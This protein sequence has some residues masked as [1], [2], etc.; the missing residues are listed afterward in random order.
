MTAKYDF[1]ISYNKADSDWAQWI[2]WQLDEAGYTTRFQEWDFGAGSNFALEM[3]RALMETE[4]TVAVLSPSSLKSEFCAQEWAATLAKD[5]ASKKRKLI[6][7]RVQECDPPGLLASIAYIDLFGKEEE[8]AKDEF[9][10]MVNSAL[11][12]AKGERAKPSESPFFPTREITAQLSK[13]QFPG[14]LPAIWRVPYN[15]NPNFTGRGR[16]LESL[17][18]QLTLGVP[19]ALTQAVSGL[20]GVGKTQ[21]ALEYTF[22]YMSD[23]GL[24][25]WV[26]SE[27]PTTM[28]ADIADLATPLGL[29]QA[30]MVEQDAKVAAVLKKLGQTPDW[31]LVFDNAAGPEEIRT[32]LPQ[33]STG[34][35]IITSRNDV[36][37]RLAQKVYVETF[38]RKESIEFLVKRTGKDDEAGAN[39]LAD[40]L[41]DLP[42]AL[43]QAGAYIEETGREFSDY[44]ELLQTRRNELLKLQPSPI[45]YPSTVLTTWDI[46]MKQVK[47]ESSEAVCLLNLFSFLAPD[48]IPRTLLSEIKDCP[49]KIISRAISDPLLMDKAIASLKRYSLVEMKGDGFFVHRL[50]QAVVRDSLPPADARNLLQSGFRIGYCRNAI[51]QRRSTNLATFLIA[52]PRMLCAVWRHEEDFNITDEN[53][54][55]LLNTLGEYFLNTAKLQGAK[56]VLER[57]VELRCKL[58]GNEHPDTAASLNSLGFLLQTIGKLSAA[59][60]YFEKALE[61]R[62]KV[63]GEEHPDTATSLNNIGSLLRIDGRA[64]GGT[65]IL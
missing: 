46:S 48:D 18:E 2:A 59:R 64:V 5:P 14:T 3:N 41:G 57:A 36:W 32:F 17:R 22:R 50:V 30:A 23:Y 37:H 53:T 1:F 16:E 54:A 19:A 52:W 58:L 15:R 24:I 21:L 4:Y 60:P 40:E 49:P 39:L 65:A 20:G 31:L 61:I 42:L 29:S 25:W 62:R 55:C 45:D 35:I 7:V 6:S 26:R 13:P 9:I 33:T 38:D 8:A 10:S 28:A 27:E 47:K 34:H 56:Q 44:V 63:L 11:K 12:I 51:K 43:E